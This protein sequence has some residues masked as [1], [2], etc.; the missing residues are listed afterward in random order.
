MRTRACGLHGPTTD[1]CRTNPSQIIAINA[2]PWKCYWRNC[3]SRSK[4]L[5]SRAS[6]TSRSPSVDS[7]RPSSQV[8]AWRNLGSTHCARRVPITNLLSVAFARPKHPM[9]VTFQIGKGSRK[10][11]LSVGRLVQD[12][13]TVVHDRFLW[14]ITSTSR[15]QTSTFQC[16]KKVAYPKSIYG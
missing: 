12:G 16:A 11:L 14:E 9:N 4:F 3:D 7:L 1:V 8:V 10:T 5:G 2:Y 13:C 6:S 15:A